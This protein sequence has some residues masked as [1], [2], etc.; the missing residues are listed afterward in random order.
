[1]AENISLKV[2]LASASKKTSGRHMNLYLQGDDLVLEPFS[3]K[4]SD[5]S[6]AVFHI[7]LSSIKDILYSGGI[8]YNTLTLKSLSLELF[9]EIPGSDNISLEMKV[10][11][12]R[13]RKTKRFVRTLKLRHAER[14]IRGRKDSSD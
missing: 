10:P 12:I 14:M 6:Q 7:P 8:I 1:M 13:R 2:K 5:G 9:E 3:G 4:P 11:Q